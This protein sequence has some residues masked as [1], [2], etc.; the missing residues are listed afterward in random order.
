VLAALV[1]VLATLAACRGHADDAPGPRWRE[2]S[3]PMPPGAPGRLA[4]R[5]ATRCA[6]SWYV[7]G[8]VLLDHPTQ[9]QDSRPAAWRSTDGSSWE[10]VPIDAH[11]FWGQRAILYSVACGR[12]TVAVVGARSGGAHGN[13]RVT[14]FFQDGSGLHDVTA[15]F[16]RYGGEQA[17]NVGP[18]AG[19]DLG[20][21]IAGNRTSGPAVW[22]SPDGRSFELEEGVPGLADDRDH[23]ALAQ[24][25]A[26]GGGVWTVVGGTRTHGSLNREPAVWTSAT[27]HGWEPDRTIAGGPDFDDLERIVVT[28]DGDLVAVGISGSAFRTWRRHGSAWRT[29]ARFGRIPSDSGASPF[30]ASAASGSDGIWATTSDGDRYA[31]WH[32][33]DGASWTRVATPARAPATAGD[34]TLAVATADAGL[35]LVADDGRRGR[36]WV[37]S[38]AAAVSSR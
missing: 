11:T 35:V 26:W 25:A 36:A 1:L 6:D 7:V 28:D 15:P 24:A 14:T 13:P 4:V 2:A 33:T 37:S 38:G 32:S 17:T 31:L 8:G 30:V 5:A 10:P 3:L 20:W 23:D 22:F 27:G 29:G 16:T 18:I 34:H 9:D 12:G 21:L 19:G